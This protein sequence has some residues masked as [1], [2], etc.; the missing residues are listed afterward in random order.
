MKRFFQ[1]FKHLFAGLV[2]KLLFAANFVVCLFI[3]DWAKFFRYLEA[4][5]RIDCH[6]KTF[7]RGIDICTSSIFPSFIEPI[8]LLL[9]AIFFILVYPSIAVTE[10]VLEILKAQFPL[11]CV[12]THDILYVPVFAVVNSI[13][14]LFLGDMIEIAHSAYLQNK[15]IQKPLSCFPDSN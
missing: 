6:I 15:Q 5:A 13:Y 1:V 9:A 2:G 14:W 8:L 10:I 7:S 12:E 3:F 4:P 11:W